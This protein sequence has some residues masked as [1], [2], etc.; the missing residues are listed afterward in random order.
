MLVPGSN[1]HP[2][3]T[4]TPLYSNSIPIQKEFSRV[5]DA[6]PVPPFQLSGGEVSG[7]L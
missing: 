5:R 3:E 1:C 4:S 2:A 7:L 6:S